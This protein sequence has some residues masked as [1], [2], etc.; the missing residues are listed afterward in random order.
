MAIDPFSR[1]VG[2][3]VLEGGDL[4]VDWGTRSTGSAD[5]ARAVRVIDKLIDRFRPDILAMED[6][7]STGSRRCE[8]IQALLNR[9][10]AQEGRAGLVRLVS[11]LDIQSIG[12]LPITSTKEGRA[13]LLAERFPE[14]RP[15]LPPTRKIWMSEDDRMAIF[16]ALSFAVACLPKPK[17]V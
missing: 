17:R 10:A 3:A 8:R 13:R 11:R 2:F 6:W 12:R 16:D 9:I 4:L 1:G 5:N 15:F 14:V 7:D